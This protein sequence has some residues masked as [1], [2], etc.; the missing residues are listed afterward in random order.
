M[1]TTAVE[2]SVN[3]AVQAFREQEIELNALRSEAARLR[4]TVGLLEGE[5]IQYQDKLTVTTSERDHYMRY[6][7]EVTAQLGLIQSIIAAIVEAASHMAYRSTKPTAPPP[8]NL[9]LAD[10]VEEG[11][12]KLVQKFGANGGDHEHLQDEV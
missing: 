9:K 8:K 5:V 7:T 4:A 2:A 11:L 12:R 10:D 6:A 1:N 3:S